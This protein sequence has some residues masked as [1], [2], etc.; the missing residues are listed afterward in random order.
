V[1][2]ALIVKNS[3]LINAET[4]Q[5]GVAV[6]LEDFVQEVLGSNLYRDKNYPVVFPS[7][8]RQILF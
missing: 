5:V 2:V 1:I 8:S 4:E 6:T 7:L 3:P